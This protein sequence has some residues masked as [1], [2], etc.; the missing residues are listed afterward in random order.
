MLPRRTSALRGHLML[1]T[2]AIALIA[3]PI[4]AQETD[5]GVF[6][7]LGRI[8]FGAGTAKVAIDTP[9]AVTVNRANESPAMVRVRFLVIVPSVSDQQ[10]W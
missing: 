6:Q 5:D 9:Q 10:G 3:S 8:I 7:M 1:S 2:V 4:A